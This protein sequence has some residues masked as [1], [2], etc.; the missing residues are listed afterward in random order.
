[1]TTIKALLRWNPL[2]VL[3]CLFGAAGVAHGAPRLEFQ[4]LAWNAG[5]TGH[6]YDTRIQINGSSASIDFRNDLALGYDLNPGLQLTWYPGHPFLPDLE[7]AYTHINSDGDTV[8]HADITWGGVTYA[9]N[10]HVYSQV[11]LKTGHLAA[12]WNPVDNRLVDVRA[13]VEARWLNLNIPVSGKAVQTLP[14]QNYFEAHTSGG[15]VVWLPMWHLGL[16]VHATRGLDVLCG[17]S[18]IQYG[19]SYFFDLRAGLAYQFDSGLLLSAGWRRLRLHFDDSH[20]NVNGDMVFKGTYAGV[21]Y[22]F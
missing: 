5:V 18:Y 19:K 2:F 9:A 8:L 4:A 22:R 16:I 10:G 17:G 12:F 3:C 7:V 11:M 14:V 21:G 13:G 20:F 1:M 6:A 15:N